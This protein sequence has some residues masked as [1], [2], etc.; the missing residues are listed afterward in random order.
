MCGAYLKGDKKERKGVQEEKNNYIVYYL[1]PLVKCLNAFII[2]K[3][4]YF[5]YYLVISLINYPVVINNFLG[6]Y[7]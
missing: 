7:K 1:F 3:Y 4:P 6:F 2:D 5:L